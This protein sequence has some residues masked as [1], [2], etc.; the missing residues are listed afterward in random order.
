MVE[1]IGRNRFYP[2]H[3]PQET[4]FL[5]RQCDKNKLIPSIGSDFHGGIYRGAALSCSGNRLTKKEMEKL[6]K[7]ILI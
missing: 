7:L 3:S 2:T 6:L 1:M 5:R 4:A